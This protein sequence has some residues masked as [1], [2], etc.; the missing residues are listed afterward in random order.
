MHQNIYIL[1]KKLL[2]LVKL[3]VLIST[4]TLFTTM[5]NCESISLNK[6]QNN[7]LL[8]S[9]LQFYTSMVMIIGQQFVSFDVPRSSYQMSS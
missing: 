4:P 5:L 1:K 7:V 6:W 2:F 9:L 8:K 3:I